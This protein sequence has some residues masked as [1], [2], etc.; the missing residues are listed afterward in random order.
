MY[1]TPSLIHGL[2]DMK[3]FEQCEACINTTEMRTALVLSTFDMIELVY[4]LTEILDIG[5]NASYC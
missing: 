1:I 3:R 2:Q 5:T 4:E